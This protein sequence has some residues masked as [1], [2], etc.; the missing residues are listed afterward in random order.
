VIYLV[1]DDKYVR[2]GFQILLRSA[3]LESKSFENV[4]CF[5]KEW[6]QEVS[7]IL[8]L[9]IHMPGMNGYD[10][11]AWLKESGLHLPVIVVTAFDEAESREMAEN[12]GVLAYLIKPV[13][14]EKLL[15]LIKNELIKHG[16]PEVEF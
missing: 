3:N 11:M 7:D 4:E 5:R 1:D 2:R 16:V 9:D 15:D 13:D 10:L 14:P 8:I 12:Y 6:H